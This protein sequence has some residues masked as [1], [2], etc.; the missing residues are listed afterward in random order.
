MYLD[1]ELKI[2][3]P[4]SCCLQNQD[5]AQVLR[6]GILF[7]FQYFN[8]FSIYILLLSFYNDFKFSLIYSVVYNLGLE[9][10]FILFS[11]CTHLLN[12]LNFQADVYTD[13][14]GACAAFISNED[15]KNDKTIEFRNVSYHLPAWSVS[16]LPDC[17]NVVFNT[18]KVTSHIFFPCL[19]SAKYLIFQTNLRSWRKIKS[20]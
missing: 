5:T 19:Y 8:H 13:S 15:D 7:T 18:A 2:T 6:G 3:Y 12:N 16:I 1:I 4:G 14:S 17:K 10:A 20:I 9:Y 11:N